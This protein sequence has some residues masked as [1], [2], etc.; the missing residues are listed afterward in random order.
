MPNIYIYI[1]IYPKNTHKHM[2]IGND[3]KH[4]QIHAYR[5]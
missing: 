3:I 1:Y 4:T 2:H 5:K